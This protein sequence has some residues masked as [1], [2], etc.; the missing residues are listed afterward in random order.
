MEIKE[1]LTGRPIHR[2]DSS[3]ETEESDHDEILQR[4]FGVKKISEEP[5]EKDESASFL[6][7]HR[8]REAKWRKQHKG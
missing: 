5:V 8:R 2:G 6:A 3:Q 7:E 4:A 1:D